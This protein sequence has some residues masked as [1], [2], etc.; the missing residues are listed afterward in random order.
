MNWSNKRALAVLSAVTLVAPLAKAENAP[1]LA[2]RLGYKATD[3]LLIINGDDTGM[4]HAANDATIDSLERGLMTSATILVPCPWFTEIARYA[5]ANPKIDFGIH[6]AHTSEWQ[7]Y[8]W[9]PVASRDKVPGLMDKDGYLWRSVFEV[10]QH[11][12]PEEAMIEARAQIR[13]ALDAGIDVTHLDT[14]MGTLNYDPRYIQVYQ[15]LAIEFDLPLRMPSESTAE[16]FGFG[17]LRERFAS[18]GIV[19][20]DYLIFDNLDEAKKGVKAFWMKKLRNLKP[21]VTE[22]FIHAAKPTDELRHITNSWKTRGE[23]YE[24]FTNDAEM[25]Q[26]VTGERIIRIG[27]R[28]LRELQ[29][30]N[31]K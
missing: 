10:Y 19:F 31:N 20:P 21:G 26:L 13:K 29:R 4:C 30:A 7:V 11:A 3:K 18:K 6:L 17:G 1:T 14:H 25:K 22:L 23:E 9:G 27:Y 8:R 28:P 16:R 24:V 2:E 12:T 15:Q 5:K